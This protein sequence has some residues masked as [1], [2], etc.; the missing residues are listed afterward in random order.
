MGLVAESII[1]DVLDIGTKAVQ[2]RAVEEKWPQVQTGKKGGSERYYVQDLLPAPIQRALMLRQSLVPGS[3]HPVASVDL[4]APAPRK[5][6]KLGLA[7]FQLVKAYRTSKD[8]AGHGHKTQ[9]AKAFVLAYNTGALMP[10]VF[11]LVGTVTKV[12]LDKLDKR[13]RANKEDYL[14]LCDGRGG[15]RKHGTTKWKQRGL[16]E[17][18]KAIFL[19]CYLN[20]A[21]PSVIM[22]IRA[23]RFTLDK[24]GIIEEAS[25]KTFRRWL[26]DY[27]AHNA[28]VICMAREGMKAYI[29]HY[30]PYATRDASLL[31]V[32]Q[33]LVADGKTLNFFIRHPET[34]RPCRMTLIVF[35]DW[36]SRYP[37]GWQIMPGEDTLAIMA[38][39]R[40]SVETLG[41]YP[42]SV[43]LDNG[44]AFKS[45]FFMES[46]PDLE[47]LTG[48][49]ARVGT[50]V[51]FAKPYNGRAKVVERWFQT[52]QSQVEFMMPSYCGDSIQTKPAW[53]ARNEKFHKAWH[54]ARTDGWIPTVREAAYI[55]G[56]YFEWYGNQPH[57]DLPDTPR[58]LMIA[59]QGPG[60]DTI[61]LNHDF[62]WRKQ[63]TPHNCRV[64]LWGIDYESDGLHGL[65]KKN[66]LVAMY[67]TANMGRIW[68]Y[69]QDG[70]YICEAAPVQ[71]LHPLAR[72]F[73][74]EVSMT[75]VQAHNKRMRRLEK[76][77][78]Q[79]LSSAGISR[80]AQDTLNI[81]PWAGKK[82]PI[83]PQSPTGTTG[84]PTVEPTAPEDL[85]RYESILQG[86]DT[87]VTPPEI[88][89]MARLASLLD[90]ED[91]PDTKASDM[92][93]LER[94]LDDDVVDVPMESETARLAALLD[95]DDTDQVPMDDKTARL[96]AILQ[97]AGQEEAHN[98]I[99]GVTRPSR[100]ESD[101]DRYEWTF[102]LIYEHGQT[103][104]PED[105]A[106]YAEFE[107]RPEYAK[108]QQRFEDLKL[109][110]T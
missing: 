62:L 24:H 71:A 54:Q 9:A 60:V 48:L 52:V 51:A 79:Q 23:A 100:F 110:Y 67:D 99:Q 102:R 7:K 69:T 95:D 55:L 57:S 15:W 87:D 74:D 42:Q 37:V 11:D 64:T 47:E 35:L 25:D 103:P 3:I 19:K 4:D 107:A 96:A 5:A 6:Q 26:A 97:A 78:R 32:G 77:T 29:D 98:T 20:P 70:V 13:L 73:G 10:S 94:L 28:H 82:V 14:C 58:N 50:A 104:T 44:R 83:L 33:C 2:L 86:T 101:L 56:A 88:N 40:N 31:Q 66:K 43:Y 49:Y 72:L 27:E 17:Q 108:Y 22:S 8:S 61:Q 21:R 106:F 93:R 89:D 16:T 92:S 109:I 68:C 76:E 45:K 91:A 18:A 80:K 65:S 36:A 63:V 12:T 85:A 84:K 30:G 41:M 46:D 1:S 59:N 90:H 39:F 38:A 34:G 75:Q 53:M 81:L 105:R